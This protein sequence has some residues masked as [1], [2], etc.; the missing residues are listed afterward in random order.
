MKNRPIPKETSVHRD[1]RILLAIHCSVHWCNP[2]GKPPSD[3]LVVFH[4]CLQLFFVHDTVLA[5]DFLMSK[6]LWYHVTF[7]LSKLLH[8]KFIR[9]ALLFG[10]HKGN[11]GPLKTILCAEKPQ[12]LSVFPL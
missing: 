1:V 11:R 12:K 9:S 5:V 7:S 4:F 3:V 8:F 2:S 10:I 6:P